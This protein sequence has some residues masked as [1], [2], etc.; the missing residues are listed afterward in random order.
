MQASDPPAES[1][2][3][4]VFRAG[5][6]PRFSLSSHQGV[7]LTAARIAWS[8][9]GRDD[10]AP[11]SNIRSVRLESSGDEA[12]PNVCTII[13]ADGYRL[14][15]TSGDANGFADPERA[16]IYRDFLRDLHARLAAAKTSTRFEAGYQGHR[17]PLTIAVMILIGSISIVVPLF[18]IIWQGSISAIGL[19]FAGAL[20]YLPMMKAIEKN[21][22]RTYT[23]DKV[24]DE[25]L[26]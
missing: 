14:L 12:H 1:S 11:F 17:Y 10:G 22:P 2:Y 19:L 25:M 18:A 9:D 23:P 5:A 24:P 15:I 4:L 8:C 7:T 21:A 16:P 26:P 20:L 13:F 6:N 3:D